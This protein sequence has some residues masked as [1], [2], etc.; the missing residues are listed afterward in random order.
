MNSTI[1]YCHL[2]RCTV[3][4]QYN[5]CNRSTV[6]SEGVDL[7]HGDLQTAPA[8]LQDD[9]PPSRR[10]G[11][12]LPPSSSH[13]V[14]NGTEPEGTTPRRDGTTTSCP[15][16]KKED[17]RRVK[18]TVDIHPLHSQKVRFLF[19]LFITSSFFCLS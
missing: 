7:S 17:R 3:V 9:H 19:S 10:Q 1:L 8:Y 11:R 15:R 6:R 2:H 14:V 18:L 4:L 12:P 5:Y 16:L 13:R